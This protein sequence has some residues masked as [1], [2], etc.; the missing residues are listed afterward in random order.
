MLYKNGRFVLGATRG[1]GLHGDDIT[2]NLKTIR[3]IPLKILTDDKELM[4]IE[5]RGEVFLPKKSFDRLN[6][7]RKKQGLPIFANP[8]NAAAGTL[9]LLDSRE[10]AKRGLDIFIHTI[11]EQPGSKYWN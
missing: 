7:K 2:Q 1:D 9:K 3:T 5:A 10:V 6:K 8:R 11:P 4:D